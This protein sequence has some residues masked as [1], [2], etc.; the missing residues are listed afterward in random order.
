ML[1]TS[2]GMEIEERLTRLES[3]VEELG[4]ALGSG[5]LRVHSWPVRP[6]P[7]QQAAA[8]AR[9]ARPAFRRHTFPA[10]G[11]RRA[12]DPT[13]PARASSA[14]S[15]PTPALP[16]LS[17]GDLLGGRV[18]AWLGGIATLI[19]IVLFLALAVSRGW[20]GEEARVGLAAAAS[21]ALMA[22]GAW[23]HARRGRTEA[24]KAMVGAATAGLFATLI[25]ASQIY[26]LIPPALAIALSLLVGGIA[27][28][29][30]IRWA[31][32]AIGSLGLLGAQ[33][34]PVLVGASPSPETLA[35]VALANA[36]TVWVLI[37]QRW[38]W[39]GLAS[40]LA[41]APQWASWVLA[42]QATGAVVVV[43]VAFAALG[44][45]G[46]V[47]SQIR[48]GEGQ[49]DPTSAA[50][51][52]LS[53]CLVAVVGRVALDEAA[54]EALAELWLGALAI[55]H[56]LVGVCRLRRVQIAAPMRHLLIAI[57]VV[58]ADVA[59]GLGASGIALT[60][61]WGCA[62]V[63]FAWLV[64]RT[65]AHER[66]QQLLGLGL[67][68]HIA[69]AL[70]RAL[71]L[72]PPDTLGS[73]D[74]QLVPLLAV[75]VLAASCLASAHLIGRE[76]RQG[77]AGL[78]AVGLA[79]IAY[80]TAAALGGPALVFAWCVEAV[81]LMRYAQ[82]SKDAVARN[83]AFGFLGL[84]SLH[85][86]SAEAP[87]PA[88]V[89]G[90]SDLGAAAAA[91]GPLALAS[92]RAGQTQ[93]RDALRRWLLCGSA[94]TLLYLVSVAI[95]TVFQPGSEA[96]AEVVLDLS[97]RQQGQVLL[98]ALWSVVGLVALIVGLR[99][100]YDAVR[101]V[102]L[103]WLLITVGKVFL[104]DL[105]TLTSIYRVVSFVVL[106]LLLLAGAYAYQR[107]RPPP[108]PDMRSLHPSQR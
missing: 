10:L 79:S 82:A 17:M 66:E 90:V 99:K 2:H 95:V 29:L 64:R 34:S 18:L 74:A 46:A 93:A 39:L 14:A 44:V 42:G 78:N 103:G 65:G 108:P 54:G 9:G 57:G 12:A 21:C 80:L 87:P 72:A 6:A 96:S 23:L 51:A 67:G 24:A 70:I 100:R 61:G 13:K 71:V 86:L 28:A 55:V 104:Y 37:R 98:S 89:T 38:A 27:T 22:A 59:F 4:W 97:V 94:A 33:L 83:G 3:R 53:A 35:V 25:V 11:T 56:T 101:R 63:G 58:L 75:S 19:G 43:L 5:P 88:L 76:H 26:E 52:A 92:A 107:L 105:S 41:C 40:L 91:L 1:E 15:W 7:S 68:A 69:L 32:A 8:S 36:C 106:G 20:I 50:L 102:A 60:A 47:G 62:A 48:S 49:L 30:A 31:G 81:A 16:D 77:N 85:A 84:A 73:G 45:L